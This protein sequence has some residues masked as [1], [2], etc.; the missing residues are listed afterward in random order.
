MPPQ[1]SERSDD[2]V[3]SGQR[4]RQP[5]ERA[6][7]RVR[8]P[9]QL[10]PAHPVGPDPIPYPLTDADMKLGVTSPATRIVRR[11]EQA[12]A[13]FVDQLTDRAAWRRC[14]RRRLGQCHTEDPHG[15]LEAE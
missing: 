6:I 14:P 1:E 12:T 2:V 15:E 8:P 4:P 11:V 3:E 13:L 9:A 7:A 5:H 10:V